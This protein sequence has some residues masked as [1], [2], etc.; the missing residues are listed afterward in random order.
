V[1]IGCNLTEF[2]KEGCSS[3]KACFANYNNYDDDNDDIL[4]GI[5]KV[6]CKAIPVTGRKNP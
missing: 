6:I 3:K 1:K 4:N 5:K 2:S